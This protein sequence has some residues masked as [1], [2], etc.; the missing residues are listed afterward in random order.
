MLRKEP[1]SVSFESVNSQLCF[2]WQK[3]WNLPQVWRKRRIKSQF[4]NDRTSHTVSPPCILSILKIKQQ[5]SSRP[6]KCCKILRSFTW[7][8][9]KE[10]LIFVQTKRES[11]S[12][13]SQVCTC[14]WFCESVN[15]QLAMQHVERKFYSPASKNLSLNISKRIQQSLYPGDNI[16]PQFWR[17]FH[18][19]DCHNCHLSSLHANAANFTGIWD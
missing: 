17:S 5:N 18:G 4:S 8:T 12:C 19:Q 10:S 14:V 11:N 2:I 6:A 1:K 13:I 15:T 3:Q 16:K 7:R 9:L